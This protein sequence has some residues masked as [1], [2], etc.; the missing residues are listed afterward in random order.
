MSSSPV[1]PS[2]RFSCCG[3]TWPEA[4]HGRIGVSGG[5][6]HACSG[7]VLWRPACCSPAFNWFLS[8][9]IWPESEAAAS[10][11]SWDR[12]GIPP[13][14]LLAWV[15]PNVF[16][17][18]RDGN[19]L[20]SI[21][22]VHLPG[23]LSAFQS[24]LSRDLNYNEMM[25]GYIGSLIFLLAPLSLLCCRHRRLWPWAAGMMLFCYSVVLGVPGITYLV[26]H[27][28]GFRVANND[29][30]SL[31]AGFASL[32][33]AA[34]ML[35]YLV[36]ARKRLAAVS[37]ES[38]DGCCPVVSVLSLPLPYYCFWRQKGTFSPPARQSGASLAF[39]S[40]VLAAALAGALGVLRRNWGVTPALIGL[41]L[42]LF[43]EASC[44]GLNY[45]PSF[46]L[47]NR[48]PVTPGIALLQQH[49]AEG[50]ILFLGGTLPPDI[51]TMYGPSRSPRL[52]RAWRF[53][54]HHQ[55]MSEL[56]HIQ[57]QQQNID[58]IPTMA[59]LQNCNARYPWNIHYVAVG[60]PSPLAADFLREYGAAVIYQGPDLF[61]ARVT[62][63]SR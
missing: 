47:R 38:F 32:I 39:F 7:S 60:A 45:N 21:P 3:N 11:Y 2:L 62:T 41:A 16:G 43:M 14:A 12:A 55:R 13:R 22:S 6:P 20:V 48:Y 9:V 63:V 29:R 31:L 10:A 40:F 37:R 52:R 33:N 49:A 46:D 44:M 5:L 57:G 27:L 4:H 59:S 24:W 61:I 53:I 35:D 15:A 51:P 56:F 42:L 8:P 19:S 30:L 50:S 54:P 28:P 25:G 17:N 23:A 58:Y 18:P 34:Y 26:D 1:P 36:R